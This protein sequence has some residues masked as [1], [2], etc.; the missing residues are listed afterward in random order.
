VAL[1]GAVLTV[2]TNGLVVERQLSEGGLSC[3]LCAGRLAPWGYGRER[4][5]R[6]LEGLVRLRPR[7][8]RCGSCRRTHVLLPATLLLRR[9]DEAAVIGAALA[10]KA[11]GQGHRQIAARLDRPPGT[12]RGW[13]RRFASRADSLRAGFTSLLCGLDPD[14]VLPEPVGSPLADAVAAIVAAAV[15][16]GRRWK[17]LT[18]SVWQL[19]A[20]ITFGCLLAPNPPPIL[21]NTSCLW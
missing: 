11:A 5:I 6:G 3:P 21:I 1:G 16:A 19:A 4:T 14:P 12:V 7:R 18:M 2:G 13:L 20:A 10:A 17:L 15:A 9:A 8:A